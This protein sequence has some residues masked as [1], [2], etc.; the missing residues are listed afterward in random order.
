MSLGSASPNN[1][2]GNTIANNKIF[3][4]FS[5]TV[6]RG[7]YQHL[8]A[9]TPSSPS[10]T[11]ESTRLR[12]APLR[13]SAHLFRNFGLK[14]SRPCSAIITG[15]TIG[16]GAANGTGTT[17]ISGANN[18]QRNERPSTSTDGRDQRPGE[19]SF[20]VRP[21]HGQGSNRQHFGIHRNF[22]WRYGRFI[23]YRRPYR[24]HGWQPG[25][26]I[27]YRS[28]ITRRNGRHLGLSSVYSTLVP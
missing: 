11:T 23:P 24:Q 8:H 4:F 22:S 5:P 28:S 10:P 21:D 20:W 25:W 17:T 15:N 14:S 7:G 13:R 12:R 16:F 3:D 9:T 6:T 1:N 19:Y 18:H 2:T 26:L 27:G